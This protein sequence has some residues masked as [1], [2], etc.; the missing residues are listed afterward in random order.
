M[1][2]D[3]EVKGAEKLQ[4]GLKRIVSEERKRLTS[5]PM[6]H[7]A[8]AVAQ[9]G[10]R[11]VHSPRGHARTFR[12]YTTVNSAVV[13]PGSRAN[14]FSQQFKPIL[15]ATVNATRSRIDN[16]L[17]DAIDAAVRTTFR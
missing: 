13:S 3:V 15:H 9:E 16:I 5:G 8:E 17:N 11:R 1:N 10:N 14:F 7:A 2:I 4:N 6:R 12:V